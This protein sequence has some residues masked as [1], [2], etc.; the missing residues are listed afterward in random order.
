MKT[1][2]LSIFAALFVTSQAFGVFIPGQER[3]QYHADLMVTSATGNLSHT[4][5][6]QIMKY[7]VDGV[8]SSGFHLSLNGERAVR[9]AV[10]NVRSIGC[11]SIEIVAEEIT[12]L[13]E[14]DGDSLRMTVIDHSNRICMDLIENAISITIEKFQQPYL[15]PVGSLEAEGNSQPVYTIQ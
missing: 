14:I 10:Q 4:E 9:L 13:N 12:E 6:V 8:D 15:E 11:G 3:P 2:I 7:S 1:T 5:R